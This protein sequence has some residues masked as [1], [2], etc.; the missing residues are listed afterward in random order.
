MQE[1]R[2]REGWTRLGG[3][4][5]GAQPARQSLLQTILSMTHVSSSEAH[6]HPITTPFRQM[7]KCHQIREVN[8]AHG[9]TASK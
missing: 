4:Q 2:L 9:Y 5:A 8:F 6:F 3:R 7:R 1:A